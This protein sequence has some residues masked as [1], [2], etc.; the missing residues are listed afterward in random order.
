MSADDDN[1]DSG[2]CFLAFVAVGGNTWNWVS[3]ADFK[4]RMPSSTKCDRFLDTFERE[5]AG[6][7]F[8]TIVHAGLIN[9]S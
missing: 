3:I 6:F 7:P 4:C 1:D 5:R 8:S 9:F 2:W